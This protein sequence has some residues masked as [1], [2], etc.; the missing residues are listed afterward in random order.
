MLT[1]G[2]MMVSAMA[3]WAQQQKLNRD[4]QYIVDR[5]AIMRILTPQPELE[6]TALMNPDWQKAAVFL[7]NG[8]Q[9][10]VLEV[11]YDQHNNLVPV[12]YDNAEYSINGIAID[13]IVF[14]QTNETLISE[15]VIKGVDGDQLLVRLYDGPGYTLYKKTLIDIIKPNYNEI[16]NVGSR[17][18]KVDRIYKYLLYSKSEEKAYDFNN[19]KD[20]KALPNYAELAGFLKQNKPGMREDSDLVSIAEA[21]QNIRQ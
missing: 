11:N 14:Q 1:L 6:G 12:L 9:G 18:Y 4:P 3:L 10:T 13:S 5:T 15:T 20:L 17:N 19:K 7:S 16:L 8:K 2:V 21:Y